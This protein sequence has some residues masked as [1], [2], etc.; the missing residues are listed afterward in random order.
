MRESDHESVP[1]IGRM[2][3][4]VPYES[5]YLLDY[6]ER[7]LSPSSKHSLLLNVGVVSLRKTG[8]HRRKN[9]LGRFKAF[10]VG[11][12]YGSV[13]ANFI[14]KSFLHFKK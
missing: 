11:S 4:P 3:D 6:G 12:R 8:S 13:V 5:T 10:V 14:R 2:A 9:S 7:V 1:A